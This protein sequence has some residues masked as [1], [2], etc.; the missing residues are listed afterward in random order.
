MKNTGTNVGSFAAAKFQAKRRSLLAIALVAVIGFSMAGCG[1]T[2]E[3]GGSMGYVPFDDPALLGTWIGSNE[4]LKFTEEGLESSIGTG[5][6][7]MRG[8][9]N[10]VRELKND[11]P[12]GKKDLTFDPYEFYSRNTQSWLSQDDF[13]AEEWS[14]GYTP[15]A[16][17]AG[18]NFGVNAPYS[19]NGN[20]LTWGGGTYTKQ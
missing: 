14:P 5:T 1:D 9:Y 6:L 4:E 19:I 3:P 7:R 20:T 8:G 17:W 12:T 15:N 2:E 11:R 13:A 10:T 18:H 16:V